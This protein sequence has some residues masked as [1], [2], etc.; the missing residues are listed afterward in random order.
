MPNNKKKIAKKTTVTVVVKPKANRKARRAHLQPKT[1]AK[2]K[3]NSHLKELSKGGSVSKY[4]HSIENPFSVSNTK[5]PDDNTNLS[6]AAKSLY[7]YTSGLRAFNRST[8]G[9]TLNSGSFG[10]LMSPHVNMRPAG[11]NIYATADDPDTFCFNKT[12]TYGAPTQFSLANFT[13]LYPDVTTAGGTPFM[14]RLVSSGV[15]VS[16]LGKLLDTSGEWVA[17]LLPISSAAWSSGAISL[18]N[19]VAF[20]FASGADNVSI[21]QLMDKAIKIERR[22][23]TKRKETFFWQPNGPPGYCRVSNDDVISDTMVDDMDLSQYCLF[24]AAIGVACDPITVIPHA[25]GQTYGPAFELDLV[26]NIEIAGVSPFSH[27][28]M[29]SPSYYDAAQI[30]HA[31]N[32]MQTLSFKAQRGTTSIGSSA[33][34]AASTKGKAPMKS[35]DTSILEHAPGWEEFDDNLDFIDSTS[36]VSKAALKAVEHLVDEKTGLP[37]MKTLSSATIAALTGLIMRPMRR[38]A[39]QGDN[40]V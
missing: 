13:A 35:A 5:I 3:L 12:A 31:V 30:Q 15:T 9:I 8:E 33:R 34:V 39:A 16:Y 17:L 6:I 23:I 38:A 28:I 1:Q 29:P 19:A 24:V 37:L 22:P 14:S 20:E 4:S 36:S 26:W 27:T 11:Y 40:L 2:P 10:L 21:G 7:S 32:R 18:V 25:T